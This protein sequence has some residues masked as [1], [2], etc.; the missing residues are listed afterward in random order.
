MARI[1]IDEVGVL[2]AVLLRLRSQLALTD[3]TCR[4]IARPED[5][6]TI[7][8]GGDYFVTVAPGPG[9]YVEEEQVPDVAA[10]Q[11]DPA[12]V[13]NIT[14]TSTITVSAYTRIKTDSTDHDD[15]LLRDATRGLLPI[16]K[17]ILASLCGQDIATEDG[18]TFLR[19]WMHAQSC[20]APDLVSIPQSNATYGRIAIT[21]GIMWDW[22][23]T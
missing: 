15:N 18:D 19:E 12:R 5:V 1:D 13:S 4:L 23:L 11:N 8:A 20:S 3:R 16:K 7:P 6:P 21:F 2:D 10:T 17:A 14:E 22:K 9:T